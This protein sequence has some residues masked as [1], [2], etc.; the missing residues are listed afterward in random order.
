VPFKYTGR[1]LDPETG[2]YYYRARYYSAAL[3]RFLQADPIGYGDDMNMYA[4]VGGDPVNRVDP[5]GAYDMPPSLYVCGG[6]Y[7]CTREMVGNDAAALGAVAEFVVD[8]SP[9]IGDA[10][11]FYDAYQDGSPEAWGLAATTLIPGL[12][13]AKYGDDAVAAVNRLQAYDVGPFNS[14]KAKSVAG[15]ELDIHH[16]VQKHPAGQVIGAYDPASG[17]AIA[18]PWLEH[19]QIPNLKNFFDGT[20]RD[21]LARDLRN[22]RNYTNAP[23]ASLQKLIELNKQKFPED[24]KK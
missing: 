15:D 9:V 13:A 1:R 16:A 18:L 23:N 12:D 19:Q 20:A 6:D 2:L 11:G 5:S 4:Y 17:P 24:F 3:G 22:L 21:L 10:K 8:M 14:L 7:A